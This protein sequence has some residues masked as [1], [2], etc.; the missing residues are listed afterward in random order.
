MLRLLLLA[1]MASSAAANAES[2]EA[3]A[4]VLKTMFDFTVKDIDGND[5]SLEKYRG[6][7]AF[8]VVNVASKCGL[9]QRNYQE[10]QE[11]YSDLHDQ[12]LEILAFACNQFGAQEP[13]TEEEI[14]AFA[15]SRGATFPLFA[16]VNVNGEEA[17]PLFEFLKNSVE[18]GIFGTFLKW[19]FTKFLVDG[20]GI[21]IKR[22]APTTNP[23]AIADDI[24]ALL[25]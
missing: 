18:N 25:E 16:K 24:R 2:C 8:L 4:P 12:G 11:L 19:N 10:L 6:A 21:P 13:G 1:L 3:G 17:S 20:N 5:V 23:L 9:T 14:K 15:Q 22:Y 7:K